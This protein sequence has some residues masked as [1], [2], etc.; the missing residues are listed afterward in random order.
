[1]QLQHQGQPQEARYDLETLGK[2][3]RLAQQL[4]SQD[5]DTWS[6]AEIESM[7]AE[8]GLQ[9]EF[10]QKALGK[11]EEE[12]RVTAPKPKQRASPEALKAWRNGWWAGGWTLPLVLLA[13]MNVLGFSEAIQGLAMLAGGPIWLGVGVYLSSLCR[14]LAPAAG[15]A[16]TDMI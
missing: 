6:A 1:M 11:L 10:I 14:G 2:V 8:V 3:T 16:S 13:I 4:Q 15:V 12:R 7:G 9:P 5:K